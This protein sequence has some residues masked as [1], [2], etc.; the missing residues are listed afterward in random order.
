MNMSGFQT[1]PTDTLGSMHRSGRLVCLASAVAFG[2]MGVFGKL[3]YEEGASVG[4]L[5]AARF[6]VASALFWLVLLSTGRIGVVRALGRRD[7]GLAIALGSIVYAAQSGLTFAGLARL[8][9]S[10]L[11]LLVYVYPVLVTV[12]AVLVGRERATRRTAAALT[13]GSTGLVMVLAGSAAGALDP[14]GAVFAVAGAVIYSGY[15]LGSEGIAVRLDPLVLSTLVCTGA[16]AT[17]TLTGVATHDLDLGRVSAAGLGWLAALAVVSTVGA[18]TLFFAGLRRVGPS[19]AAI[20]STLEPVVTIALAFA[21]F[22]GSLT[23]L[24]L[25]GGALVLAAALAVRTHGRAPRV[26]HRDPRT[27]A[28]ALEEGAR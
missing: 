5:L 23:P 10:L 18:I 13:L 20:L 6:G 17:F 12:A 9:P 27:L 4:T 2:A 26:R 3:A 15:I 14:L 24:Q 25:A 19:A 16:A 1:L 22:G 7:L 28:P 11:S 21:M 8:D